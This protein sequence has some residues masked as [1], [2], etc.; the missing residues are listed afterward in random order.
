[1]TTSH[2]NFMKTKI[3]LSPH[4][5]SKNTS[6]IVSNCVEKL[7]QQMPNKFKNNLQQFRIASARKEH[8][9][10][11]RLL[12]EQQEK[13]RLKEKS[14]T[15]PRFKRNT[16]S[17]NDEALLLKSIMHASRRRLLG[18]S[19]ETKKKLLKPATYKIYDKR[20]FGSSASS[21][22]ASFLRHSVSGTEKQHLRQLGLPHALRQLKKSYA[23]IHGKAR[24]SLN[25]V[26]VPQPKRE[27]HMTQRSF[28]ANFSIKPLYAL[29]SL[30]GDL[31]MIDEL[32]RKPKIQARE[33][34]GNYSLGVDYPPHPQQPQYRN[35]QIV[36][37]TILKQ[38]NKNL[39]KPLGKPLSPQVMS[40]LPPQPPSQFKGY[41]KRLRLT[42]PTN[43]PREHWKWTAK[44][45]RPT[46][47]P[48]ERLIKAKRKPLADIQRPQVPD[49]WRRHQFFP[50]I[51][52]YYGEV[53]SSAP[54]APV[55]LQKPY[56]INGRIA[57]L[58]YEGYLN[59]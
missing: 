24:D 7:Y 11:V 49:F 6:E 18:Y 22:S 41:G 44:T 35:E 48:N 29:S 23:M 57:N 21:S 14:E 12:K 26:V 5:L 40:P 19:Q 8:T 53:E 39:P 58:A 17:N 27:Q 3:N 25:P 34:L 47:S 1:M 32:L 51:G 28:A 55:K 54:A 37:Q 20:R 59:N 36:A 2:F 15:Q 10:P 38:Q 43:S 13:E 33:S 31:M 52:H 56:K 16:P 50:L 4:I 45:T 42:N 46:I 9:A 30:Q